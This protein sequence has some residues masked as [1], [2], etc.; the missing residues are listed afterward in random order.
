MIPCPPALQLKFVFLVDF[1]SGERSTDL[2]TKDLVFLLIPV[3]YPEDMNLSLKWLGYSV[4]AKAVDCN[5]L[6]LVSGNLTFL[7]LQT[8]LVMK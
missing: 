5:I 8:S 3:F 1:P 6:E 2:G 4:G 7:V